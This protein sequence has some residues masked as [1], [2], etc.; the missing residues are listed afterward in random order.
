MFVQLTQSLNL[1][2]IFQTLILDIQQALLHGGDV[3]LSP[4]S[5]NLQLPESDDAWF[6]PTLEQWWRVRESLPTSPPQFLSILKSFWNSSNIMP[7]PSTFPRGCKVLMYGILAIAYDMRRRDDNSFSEKSLY[8]LESLGTRVG[9]SFEK[10]LLWWNQTYNHP[11]M[12][13]I[14]LWRNCACIFRLGHTLYEVGTSEWRI[15]AGN[16]NI[17]GKRIGSKE[18]TR[19]KRKIKAW[20]KQDRAHVGLASQYHSCLLGWRLVLLTNIKLDA[21]AII[22]E[23]LSPFHKPNVHCEHCRWCLYIAG[24]ICWGFGFVTNGTN[25]QNKIQDARHAREEC[26]AYLAVLTGLR[27]PCPPHIVNKTTGL[28]LVLEGVIRESYYGEGLVQE[29]L[30]SLQRLL[31]SSHLNIYNAS[32]SDTR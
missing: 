2:I 26:D 7:T 24:L 27:G 30:A 17:D 10:W 28:I 31:S 14:H 5:L 19:A 32:L 15:M 12:E 8:S 23:R 4:F 9:K 21:A 6:A 22:Q 20:T 25:P 29:S 3:S 18:Y 1:R 11:H 16:D 13:T